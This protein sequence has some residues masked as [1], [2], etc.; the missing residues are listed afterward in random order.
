M[1]LGP[2][3]SLRPMASHKVE[4]LTKSKSRKV[5]DVP[6]YDDMDPDDEN[7]G[8]PPV[9]TPE[10]ADNPHPMDLKEGL[11][12]KFIKYAAGKGGNYMDDDRIYLEQY[13]HPERDIIAKQPLRPTKGLDPSDDMV[14]RRLPEKQVGDNAYPMTDGLG[15][16]TKS[17]G[18]K[19]NSAYDVWDFD[20]PANLTGREGVGL[21][22]SGLNW[23]SKKVMQNV[24][25]P[26]KVY[27]R[28]NKDRTPF[29]NENEF[30][31]IE[32]PDNTDWHNNVPLEDHQ[33]P[34]YDY[35]EPNTPAYG[36][37]KNDTP[38]YESYPWNIPI[39]DLETLQTK[40]RGF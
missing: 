7:V 15:N 32:N 39:T 20:T 6:L 33:L 9:V 25:T 24:G 12:E 11:L 31:P 3:W 4:P 27:E 1:P 2:S 22:N 40:K 10:E 5:P 29:T 18:D 26:Y 38:D 14:Y 28:Y 17:Y 37:M 36:V 23:L 34:K 19:Y 35:K 30:G 16:Y 8:P 21:F 13:L